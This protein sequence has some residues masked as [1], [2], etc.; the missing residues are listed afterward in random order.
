MI[1]GHLAIRVDA[2][3]TI[4]AGHVMRCLA[5]AQAWHCAGGEVTF[6]FAND[7][8]SVH[9]RLRSEGMAIKVF[10]CTRGG[11]D[12]ASQT[13]MNCRKISADWVVVDGYQFDAEY[14]E[15]LKK[16]GL[17]L[18]I[19][20]DHGH[21]GRYDAD[22]VLNQNLHAAPSLYPVHGAETRLLLGTR[23]LLL[24]QEF[25]Q[26]AT[27]ERPHP[28]IAKRVLVTL[29]GGDTTTATLRVIESLIQLGVNDLEVKVL[30]GE[31]LQNQAA[32]SKAV[33]STSFRL[34]IMTASSEMPS[35]MAWADLAVSGGGSTCWELAFMGL[36]ALTMVLA[37]NQ[38]DVVQ[39]L[40]RRGI[41]VDLGWSGRYTADD[42]SSKL[43]VLLSDRERRAAM[44]RRGRALADGQGASRVVARLLD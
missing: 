14:Y 31:L 37:E 5:L 12:D 4:G 40:D 7:I 23:F 35:L 13:I 21:A 24:R 25:L 42:F 18:L 26:W 17:R 1:P 11:T 33:G 22:L 8:P 3:A 6:L 19:I 29:G 41:V 15:A 39:D 27:W 28:V 20:D 10:A 34:E 30:C 38:L 32:M 2:D 9:S 44:S 43:R 36:P 16:S